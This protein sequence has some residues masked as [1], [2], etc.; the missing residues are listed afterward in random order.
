MLSGIGYGSAVAA[1]TDLDALKKQLET[2]QAKVVEL[3]KK[4][5]AQGEK[6]KE[7]AAQSS[8]GDATVE[9]GNDKV[10]LEISGQ[11]NRAIL[12]GDNGQQ[13][14]ILSVDNDASSTR[15]RFV[16]S[17]D[18]DSALTIGTT[19]EL[20][21]ESDSSRTVGFEGNNSGFNLNERK[22]DLF[23]DHDDLGKLS[24]GQGDTASNGATEV[25]LSGTTVVGYSD[26][27]SL[28]GGL[29]FN[30]STVT[31]ANAFNNLD[32]LSREDRI[33]YDTPSFSGF[34]AST[35]LGPDSERDVALR[36]GGK[37][38]DAQVRAAAFYA[39]SEAQNESYGG[40]AS[41]LVN[42]FNAT[43]AYA[44]E[45]DGRPGADQ[46]MYYGK[47]GYKFSMFEFGG[48]AVAVDYARHDDVAAIGDEATAYGAYFVQ[49][50]DKAATELYVGARNHELDRDGANFDDIFTT[51][52][53]ARVK[54]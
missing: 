15:V 31:I 36:F 4:Q 2:L 8:S 37:F 38:G 14:D 48:S 20:E 11:V 3:E 12:F 1:E 29:N 26:V 6:V 9:S 32:G 53:G 17:A 16:G 5:H 47:L 54:F 39:D 45:D 25:D 44:E 46:K 41:V 42:G 34:R 33:R 52:V 21:A 50:V 49:K 18:V 51:L 19:I 23:F 28:A 35:S 40:S 22:L 30:G 13:S 27:A 24:L 43:L 10:R 7:V